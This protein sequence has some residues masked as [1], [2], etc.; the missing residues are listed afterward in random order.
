MFLM[1][2]QVRPL[3]SVRS[4]LATDSLALLPTPAPLQSDIWLLRDFMTAHWRDGFYFW[5]VTLWLGFVVAALVAVWSLACARALEIASAGL[6]G[7]RGAGARVPF[8]WRAPFLN[9][10]F[11]GTILV[12]STLTFCW[13]DLIEAAYER[14]V[15]AFHGPL[16]VELAADAAGAAAM[17][18][19]QFVAAKASALAVLQDC[20]DKYKRMVWFFQASYLSCAAHDLVTWIVSAAR[21]PLPCPPTCPVHPCPTLA[22][23]NSHSLH[24]PDR[25]HRRDPRPDAPPPP[26][27]QP[28]PAPQ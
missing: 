16:V 6:D 27:L 1:A 26:P 9:L 10:A 21:P 23:S 22:L 17:T 15:D 14:M 7:A 3:G 19:A 11:P 12:F 4:L 18:E 13:S 20:F 28:L 5:Q 2:L 25:H 8:Y 24:I